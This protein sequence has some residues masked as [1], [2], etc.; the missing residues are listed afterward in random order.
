VVE[1][2]DSWSN[3]A[4]LVDVSGGHETV[5]VDVSGNLPVTEIWEV[6][7]GDEGSY[8]IVVDVDQDGTYDFDFDG[9]I[10]ASDGINQAGFVVSAPVRC[11]DFEGGPD[12]APIS[13]TIPGMFFTTTE[14]FDWI[15][16]DKTTG[17]YNVHP[18]GN[19]MYVCNGNVFAWL[20]PNQGKGRIDFTGATA[21]KISMWTSTY[22]GLWLK[23]YDE[24]G[25]LLD[26][27]YAPS[28]WGTHQLTQLTV[29]A[30]TIAYV[31]VHDVG[32]YWLIDDLCVEDLLGQAEGFMAEGTDPAMEILELIAQGV[33]VT[34]LFNNPA[35]GFLQV[36][37]HWFGSEMRLTI[38]EPDGSLYG[39]YQTDS[40]PIIVGIGVAQIGQ[41]RFDITAVDV[42]E[43]DYPYALVV[44]AGAAPPDTTPPLVEIYSPIDGKRYFNTSPVS[45]DFSADD[46]ESGISEVTALLDGTTPIANGQDTLLR[47]L[48][49]HSFQVIAVNGVGLADTARVGFTINDFCW[50][51][52]IT[53]LDSLQTET[54]RVR[55]NRTWPIKFAVFD[56]AGAFVPD[57]TVRVIVEGTLV[58]FRHGEC[59]ECVRIDQDNPDDP[60]YIANLHTN[61]KRRE[62]YGI[63]IGTEYWLKT[64]LDDILAH[65]ARIVLLPPGGP[66][67]RE[68]SIPE[69]FSLSQNYP[70]P[71]NP[72]CEIAYTL[73][74]GCH[75]TLTIY[76]IL[77]QEVI[78]L[79]DEYQNAGN[80]SVTWDGQDD[81]G[82]EVTS[83]LYLY[84]LQAGDFMQVKKM[85]LMK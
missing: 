85:V 23:A 8:D 28:N 73:P 58:D 48:G 72:T 7:D 13:S 65:K 78:A 63:D 25:Q 39:E 56:S 2:D 59:D 26:S 36:I 46:P 60:K 35:F 30:P 76:N 4:A 61:F 29:D 17:K 71:F 80:Q 19:G 20:G 38:Y 77:G 81:Q 62:Q 84:R 14:G 31:L 42:P 50:L 57:T 43:D 75:V 47:H 69:R 51:R 67:A 11:M 41:W 18:Y 16:G 53:Y 64:F 44:G 21:R 66:L 82:R 68:P 45:F 54:I 9:I 27:D 3:N 83:G 24:N 70:N 34:H 74:T 49:F 40:P 79:V 32:N 5:T 10:D 1:N 15:Y 37:L 55:R 33:T 22:S 6:S 52:P 12:A